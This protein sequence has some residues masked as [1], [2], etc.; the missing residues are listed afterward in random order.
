MNKKQIMFFALL[1]AMAFNGH[2]VARAQDASRWHNVD[3]NQQNREPRRA[4]FF[5]YESMDKAQ[6]F[7]KKQSANY[8]SM[9]GT[10][11]FHF[12][13][14]YNKRPD[15]FFTTNYDDSAWANFPVPGLFE[16]NG[17]GD[18]TYKNVGYAWCTQFEPK[19]PYIAS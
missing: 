16:L 18:A 9:E 6:G 14:D 1:G 7:D 17:Y 11:K 19:P 8:L 2:G 12:V 13:K 5:A 3:V 4:A 15:R 10:W